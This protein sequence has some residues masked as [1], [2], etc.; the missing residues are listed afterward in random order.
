MRI[1]L[2][3]DVH[4]N[5]WALE[6]VLGDL[7]R[8]GAD[9]VWFLGDAVGYGPKPTECWEALR[10]VVD[11]WV[12]GNHDAALFDEESYRDMN[13]VAQAA[14]DWTRE[15]VP[16]ELV[17]FMRRVPLWRDEGD[18]YMVHSSPY[19]PD[20]WHYIFHPADA[21]AA[22]SAVNAPI[23]L[24]GHSHV[25]GGFV[26]KGQVLPFGL[27]QGKV[28]VERKLRYIL[29][30]GGVGQPRDGDPRASYGILD[31]EEGVFEVI[32]VE[33]PVEKAAEEILREGLP[34]LL[35]ERLSMGL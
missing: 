21:S 26:L 1:A 32:R 17:E 2:L 27:R 18:L 23:I 29:N 16:Q 5:I 6:R 9:E 28:K 14:I 4:G 13:P 12:L 35:A 3:S 30:P 33:Y 11:L 10:E 34:P 8:R 25:P 19:E 15:R 20:K 22:F 24:S 31:L 7:K